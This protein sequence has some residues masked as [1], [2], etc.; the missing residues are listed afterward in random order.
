VCQFSAKRV[1]GHG[2]GR[3]IWR[4]GADVCFWLLRS[5]R[6]SISTDIF[7]SQLF[8]DATQ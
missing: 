5:F 4:H 3:M 7:F 2:D 6:Q 8:A 1:K